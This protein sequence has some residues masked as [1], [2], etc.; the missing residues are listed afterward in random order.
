LPSVIR[1]SFPEQFFGLE[2]LVSYGSCPNEA[3]FI[4]LSFPIQEAVIG[5]LMLK[6]TPNSSLSTAT[7]NLAID[8]KTYQQGF[9]DF[10]S[11]AAL[12]C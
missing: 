11:S 9:G 10:R 3:A 5:K 4:G 1:H 7:H 6:V 8:I 2:T 12:K